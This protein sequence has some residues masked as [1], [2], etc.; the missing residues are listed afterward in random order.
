MK[1]ITAPW[2]LEQKGKETISVLTAYDYPTAKRLDEAGIDIVL[3]GD[4]MGMVLY[5]EEDT[6]SLTLDQMIAHMGAVSKACDRAMVIGDLPFMSYQISPEQAMQSAGR[7]MKEGRVHGVKLEGG[8]EMA[9]TVRR[10]VHCGIPVMGHIGLTPQSI[11]GLGGFKRQGKTRDQKEKLLKSARVLA[12][13]GVFSLV[14]ECVDEEL[15]SE[16]SKS[17][18]IPTIGIGSGLNCDG[19]V[20]VTEDLVG[21]GVGRVPGFVK[22]EANLGDAVFQAIKR[23]VIRT[24]SRDHQ[25]EVSMGLKREKVIAKDVQN[26]TAR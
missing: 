7:M 13:A 6:I 5:G 2:V 26:G 20:L 24:K 16:I 10:L 17:I 21:L 18:S 3:V 25:E 1:R 11:H 9:E 4:S 8:E 14:L 15:A 23:Y 19:Q 22:Q 12:E